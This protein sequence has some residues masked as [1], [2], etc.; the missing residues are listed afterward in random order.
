VLESQVSSASDD[1]MER[2]SDLVFNFSKVSSCAERS[3]TNNR[4]LSNL[5]STLKEDAGRCP[6][7]WFDDGSYRTQLSKIGVGDA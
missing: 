4:D 3:R 1:N 6:S 5:C 2:I 7:S